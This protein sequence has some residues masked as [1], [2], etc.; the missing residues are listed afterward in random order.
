MKKVVTAI[1]TTTI[2]LTG[3][4]TVDA[5]EEYEIVKRDTLWGISQQYN[6]TVEKLME[7]NELRTTLIHPGQRILVDETSAAKKKVA[8]EPESDTYTV[9]AGDTLSEIAAEY[10]V[11]YQEIMKW[12]DLPSTLIFP[13]DKLKIKEATEEKA[14]TKPKQE[15]PKEVESSSKQ[16]K[17]EV[18]ESTSDKKE[19]KAEEKATTSEDKEEKVESEKVEQN[20]KPAKSE[21]ATN[22]GSYKVV[23]GDTLS[24]VAFENNVSFEKLMEWN[25]LSST[26]IFPGQ[27]LT[28]NEGTSEKNTE[29]KEDKP[30]E[31]EKVDSTPTEPKEEKEE[32][33]K[34]TPAPE[35]VEE[36]EKPEKVEKPKEEKPKEEKVEEAPAEES[37]PSSESEAKT[38]SMEATAYT[39]ECEG[40]SGITA[41]GIDLL[42]DRNKKVI[43]VDPS[44]IPLGTKVHV[45]GYGT[46][47]AGD[48]GGAIKGNIIDVHLPTTQD[49]I[50]WGRKHDVKVTILD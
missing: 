34:E 20:D 15:K 13:G 27:T 23:A 2:A 31:T 7:K 17:E 43:A 41:T 49:A 44:V 40:C 18:K 10:N 9:V 33:V 35:K 14:E 32:P 48:V 22:K 45:E 11:T 21:S 29:V 19:E 8:K 16:E 47:V 26:L 37:K 6:M 24:G 30:K 25:N 38:L 12:N 5:A 50:N 4:A 42:A 28:L 3:A 1:T 39:A 46:A 36:K